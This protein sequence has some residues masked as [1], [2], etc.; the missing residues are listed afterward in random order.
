MNIGEIS[1]LVGT[2]GLIEREGGESHEFEM[3]GDESDGEGKMIKIMDFYFILFILNRKLY[4]D[5]R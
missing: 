3:K 4:E 1:R 5:S 2:M